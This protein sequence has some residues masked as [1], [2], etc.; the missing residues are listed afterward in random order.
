MPIDRY[1]ILRKAAEL[2][3]ITQRLMRI[4]DISAAFSGS[5]DHVNNLRKVLAEIEGLGEDDF[6]W[7]SE[8]NWQDTARRFAR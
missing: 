6:H 2:E 7:K 8:P 4:S 1:I 5:M 3:D